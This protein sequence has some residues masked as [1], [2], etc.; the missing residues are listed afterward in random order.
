MERF[1][2]DENPETAESEDLSMEGPAARRR[3]W[4]AGLLGLLFP[5]FGHLYIG[6]PWIGLAVVAGVDTLVLLAAFFGLGTMAGMVALLVIGFG[7][8][9]ATAAHAFV[10]AKRMATVE[11]GWYNRWYS[12][13]SLYVGISIVLS[14]VWSTL[15]VPNLR[16]RAFTLPTT[17]M[18][19]TILR[20]DRFIVD[21]W[22][23]RDTLP[24][25]GE[26]AIFRYP[27]APDRDMLKR[28]VGVPGDDV[29]IVN[30]R[31]LVN[32]SAVLEPYAQHTDP[33]TY[34]SDVGPPSFSS[35]D[36]LARLR[37]PAG[38]YFFLGDNRDTSL[39]SRF[40]GP[41]AASTITARPLYFYWSSDTSRI[42][43]TID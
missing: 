35:R 31:L 4:V 34:P 10:R 1:H 40:W 30:K 5:G 33:Q 18:E 32:G 13:V 6:K 26:I 19:P 37:L 2:L 14:Q 17:S 3:P 7:A 12:L 43:R 36:N 23:Y 16:Y 42:G 41:V 9:I 29:E 25:R 38:G 8:L 21:T 28:C 22:A 11:L 39:D 15:I 24:Q 20:G 27:L